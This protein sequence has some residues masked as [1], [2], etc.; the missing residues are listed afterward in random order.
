MYIFQSIASLLKQFYE[1]FLPPLS[2]ILK[3][4]LEFKGRDK[5]ALGIPD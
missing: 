5:S 2:Y 1:G 4:I 3:T